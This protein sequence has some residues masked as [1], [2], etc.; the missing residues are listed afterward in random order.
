MGL[1]GK[2]IQGPYRDIYT[3]VEKRMESPMEGCRGG[4][5]CNPL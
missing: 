4:P 3:G 2:E 5:L 1:V